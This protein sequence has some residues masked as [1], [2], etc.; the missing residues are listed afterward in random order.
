MSFKDILTVITLFVLMTICLLQGNRIGELRKKILIK[1]N[2]IDVLNRHLL[3]VMSEKHDVMDGYMEI[4][5]KYKD[6]LDKHENLQDKYKELSGD[7][8]HE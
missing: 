3:Q 5:K 7:Y 2:R 6:L 4:M 8:F 1:N